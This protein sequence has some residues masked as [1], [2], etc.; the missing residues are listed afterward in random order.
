MYILQVTLYVPRTILFCDKKNEIILFEQER[1]PKGCLQMEHHNKNVILDS[2]C[3]VQFVPNPIINGSVP[4]ARGVHS[5][6]KH[7]EQD[8]CAFKGRHFCSI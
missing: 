7:V 1:P 4:L 3:E 2:T 6:D 8:V 5:F